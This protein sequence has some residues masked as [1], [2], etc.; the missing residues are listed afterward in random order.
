MLIA[1]GVLCAIFGV[2][3]GAPDAAAESDYL[4]LVTLGFGE[5]I[6]EIF[7]NGDNIFGVNVSNGTQGITPVGLDPRSSAFDPDRRADL[8]GPRP[9]RRRCRS[10]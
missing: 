1:A 10:S 6:Y 7:Y 9:V 8:E 2:I 4:A 5:I 3:I